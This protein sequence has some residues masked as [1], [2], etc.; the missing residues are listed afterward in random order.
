MQ[1]LVLKRGNHL[2]LKVHVETTGNND[3]HGSTFHTLD[4]NEKEQQ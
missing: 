2:I 4:K 3:T 1:L